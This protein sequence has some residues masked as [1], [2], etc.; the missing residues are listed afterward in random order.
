MPNDIEIVLEESKSVNGQPIREITVRPTSYYTSAGQ[1]VTFRLR[2]TNAFFFTLFFPYGTPFDD[3]EIHS[4]GSASPPAVNTSAAAEF[5]RYHY[6]VAVAGTD[7]NGRDDV[8]VIAGCPE[9]IIR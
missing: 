7:A 8:F 5:G 1:P 6:Y 4:N 3:S 2:G 9:I